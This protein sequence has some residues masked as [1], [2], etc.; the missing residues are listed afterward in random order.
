MSESNEFRFLGSSVVTW[1]MG[2][3]LFLVLWGGVFSLDSESFTS[4]IPSIIGVPILISGALTRAK[5]AQ[6]KFWMH[7][8]VLF[9]LLAFLGGFRFFSA[10]GSEGGLF[11][12][13]KAAASQLMLLITGGLY[14]FVCVKSFVW[15]RKNA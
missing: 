2:Y 6:R 9:G 3:G 5:P 14:T 8:A 10:M 11:G 4:W 12:N 7:V 15:A 13:P 1:T